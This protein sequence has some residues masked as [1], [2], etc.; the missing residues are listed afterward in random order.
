MT[1]GDMKR[2]TR[3]SKFYVKL[4]A[5]EY[6]LWLFGNKYSHICYSTTGLARFPSNSA[7]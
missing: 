2:V 3:I 4:I 5:L 1:E 7:L 6:I